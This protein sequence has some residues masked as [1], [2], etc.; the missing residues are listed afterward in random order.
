[1]PEAAE[2]L[3]VRAPFFSASTPAPS[4]IVHHA[5]DMTGEGLFALPEISPDSSAAAGR[6]ILRT[7]R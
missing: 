4:G 1:M 3:T 2:P 6:E 5:R 7:A